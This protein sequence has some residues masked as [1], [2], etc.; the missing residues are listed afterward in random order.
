[1]NEINPLFLIAVT[2]LL[3]TDKCSYSESLS[4]KRRELA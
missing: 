1:V 2:G 4:F 3:L